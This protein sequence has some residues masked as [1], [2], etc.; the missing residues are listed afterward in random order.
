MKNDARLLPHI[1]LVLNPPYIG[2]VQYAQTG[3]PTGNP[4][5]NG[6]PNG[7]ANVGNVVTIA[8]MLNSNMATNNGNPDNNAYTG[9]I[10]FPTISSVSSG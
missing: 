7:S 10:I 5:S 6:T 1:K 3:T 4:I 8:P 9:A 2:N